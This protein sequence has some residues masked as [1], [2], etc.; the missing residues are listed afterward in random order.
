MGQMGRRAFCSDVDFAVRFRCVTRL[1]DQHAWA[2][3]NINATHN[4]TLCVVFDSMWTVA[5]FG[6]LPVDS[7]VGQQRPWARNLPCAG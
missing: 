3:D 4:P 1:T 7:G 2:H 5:C 6:G